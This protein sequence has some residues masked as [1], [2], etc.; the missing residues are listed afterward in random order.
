MVFRGFHDNYG[1]LLRRN[2]CR[3]KKP[4]IQQAGRQKPLS[5]TV[6]HC[7]FI[8]KNLVL[9]LFYIKLQLIVN[10]YFYHRI[11][12]NEDSIID[13]EDAKALLAHNIKT[14]RKKMGLSQEKLAELIDVS[15]QT[16]NDI[17]RRRSWI[18]DKTA[19]R[20]A[21]ALE[22]ELFQLFTPVLEQG[23]MD[24]GFSL[25][26][27]VVNLKQDLKSDISAYIDARFNKFLNLRES[28]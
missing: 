25:E 28:I 24:K 9:V 4:K 10:T 19:V 27:L 14:A 12:R 23:K 7:K 18:S 26:Q 11:L 16:I 20:L 1:A 2:L 15:T 13:A 5:S 8:I 21:G 3:Q 17:E 6:F 22:L